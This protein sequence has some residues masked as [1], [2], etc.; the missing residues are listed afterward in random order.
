MSWHWPWVYVTVFRWHR[1]ALN[2]NPINIIYE[3]NT[4]FPSRFLSTT[5]QKT[6][7]NSTVRCQ[8]KWIRLIIIIIRDRLASTTTVL[9][10]D[11]TESLVLRIEREPRI[12][13][14]ERFRRAKLGF[15]LMK[16]HFYILLFFPV[17][18]TTVENN[19]MH[20]SFSFVVKYFIVQNFNM[21]IKHESHKLHWIFFRVSSFTRDFLIW[22]R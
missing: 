10:D 8:T 14:I 15:V 13:N 11:S 17:G 22:K 3:S 2:T 9:I 5:L 18:K 21:N 20:N 16:V 19:G 1:I 12:N 7:L 6:T 4:W